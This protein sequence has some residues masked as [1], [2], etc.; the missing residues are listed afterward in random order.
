MSKFLR[1]KCKCGNIQTIFGNASTL[2]KCLVCNTALTKAGG[3]RAEIINGK[4]IKVL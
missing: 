1:I 2:V 4:V 3:S